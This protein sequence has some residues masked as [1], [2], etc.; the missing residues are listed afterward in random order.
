MPL[1]YLYGFVPNELADAPRRLTGIAGAPVEILPLDGIKAVISEV[2]A[3]DFSARQ[4]EANLKDLGWVA[5]RGA[6]HEA[7]VAWCVDQAQILPASLFTLY[8]SREVLE[9][10]ARAQQSLIQAELGRLHGLREW[11]LKVSYS[12]DQLAQHAGRFSE[13]V[14]QIEA[15]IAS[16]PPGRRYLLERKR[17]DLTKSEVSRLARD[18]AK[19]VL[20][21]ARTVAR[22]VAVLP[23]PNARDQLPVVLHAALLVPRAAEDEL[24]RTLQQQAERYRDSGIE[25]TFSGP[26]APYR[27]VQRDRA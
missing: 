16:A 13:A 27:F 17:G 24:I 23:L 15:E 19:Q 4:I 2:G 14:R 11:D 18:E 22:E 12:A 7:V 5:A 10:T 6:E 9:Q 26:W 8:S 21:A 25:I 3:G 20:E 1:I